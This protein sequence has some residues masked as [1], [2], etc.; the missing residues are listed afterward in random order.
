MLRRPVKTL[1]FLSL[2]TALPGLVHGDDAFTHQA[3][4]LHGRIISMDAHVDIPD[5]FATPAA[6][7][8]EDGA[9]QVDLPKLERARQS[10]AVFAVFV[11][12]TERTAESYAVAKEK[13]LN[14]LAAIQRMADQYPE[15]IAIARSAADLERLQSQ[16]KRIAVIG[17]LNGFPLGPRAELL[18]EYY[19]RGLRQFGFTH[20]GNNDLA[21]SSRPQERHG[22]KGAEHGGLSELGKSLVARLN[23]LGIIIDVSQLTPA[24]VE[25]VIASSQ[26]PVIASHSAV[27]A[28]IDH[29]RNLRDDEMRLIAQHGGVIHIVAFG[30]YL[31][32][33]PIDFAKELAAIRERYDVEDN[34]DVAALPEQ[35][36]VAFAAAVQTLRLSLPKTTMAQY[37]DAIEHAIR[38]VG[39]D[40]VGI[41]SDF[42]HGGGVVDWMN[43]GERFNLT[44]ALLRRDYDDDEVA[45]LWGLN[46]LRVF[47]EVEAVAEKLAKL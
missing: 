33:S 42:G 27:R 30:A 24:G 44:A 18:D 4:E 45:K 47:R 14:K 8:G 15:R 29:P 19:E 41:S 22:D 13:G 38:I 39:I 5:N 2:W 32:D 34:A 21:D 40:H 46:W 12:Q 25:Q 26:A 1:F 23:R 36:R 3:L 9:M 43:A 35:Q 20:A 37:V 31:R 6:D 17:M 11:P 28:R 7:P 10:G 16:G